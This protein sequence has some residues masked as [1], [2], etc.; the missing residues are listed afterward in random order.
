MNNAAANIWTAWLCALMFLGCGV[1]RLSIEG[2]YDISSYL[3]FGIGGILF[4]I[5][6]CFLPD[7]KR[8]HGIRKAAKNT[9]LFD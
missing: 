2:I 7:A 4:F 5:S 8:I 9:V 6:Y 3:S 1:V